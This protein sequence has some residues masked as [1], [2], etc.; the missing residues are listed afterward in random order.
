MSVR[1]GKPPASFLPLEPVYSNT[2]RCWFTGKAWGT[3]CVGNR[4]Q[5]CMEDQREEVEGPQE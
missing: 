2:L 4:D 3:H 5:E 1:V